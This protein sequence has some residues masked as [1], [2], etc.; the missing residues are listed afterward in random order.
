MKIIFCILSLFLIQNV[1]ACKGGKKKTSLPPA[2]EETTK[3]PSPTVVPDASEILVTVG[4]RPTKNFIVLIYNNSTQKYGSG[5]RIMPNI[6]LTSD[7]VEDGNANDFVVVRLSEDIGDIPERRKVTSVEVV[8]GTSGRINLLKTETGGPLSPSVKFNTI[9]INTRTDRKKPDWCSIYVMTEQ[10]K[11]DAFKV[12][13]LNGDKCGRNMVCAERSEKGCFEPE[14]SMLVCDYRLF[15][16]RSDNV[17]C[18]PAVYKFWSI[19]S[20]DS[21]IVHQIMPRGYFDYDMIRR[22][23]KRSTSI[24]NSA[25]NIVILICL[26]IH[27]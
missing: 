8:D 18:D 14:G 3:S 24:I 19:S 27:L 10:F 22:Q 26:Y 16:I 7:F 11:I 1:E 13:V 20:Y 21:L 9:P 25:V 23:S 15:G 12:S 2:P 6:V 17:K 4:R 5:V